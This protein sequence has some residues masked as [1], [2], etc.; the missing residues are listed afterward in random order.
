MALKLM[1]ARVLAALPGL[2]AENGDLVQAPEAT[3][4]SLA[5]AGL[6]DPHADAVAYAQGQQ[7]RIVKLDGAMAGAAAELG[8]A[9]TDSTAPAA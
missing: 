2:G 9:L 7:A 8:S 6:V 1:L 4:T 3:I 5:E